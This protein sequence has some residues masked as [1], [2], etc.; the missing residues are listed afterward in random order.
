MSSVSLT[1][2]FAAASE[3][4]LLTSRGHDWLA[5]RV[6]LTAMRAHPIRSAAPNE[7]VKKHLMIGVSAGQRVGVGRG[8]RRIS[9][10]YRSRGCWLPCRAEPLPTGS[11]GALRQ[12]HVAVAHLPQE[13]LLEGEL[14]RVGLRA[15]DHH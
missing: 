9:V 4:Q 10:V 12:P 1:C 5:S 11:T 13:V 14:G 3:A 8:R 7:P 2:G 15:G 6:L